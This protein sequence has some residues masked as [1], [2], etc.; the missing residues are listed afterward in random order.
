[1]FLLHCHGWTLVW[2]A[3]I[4]SWS[5]CGILMRSTSGISINLRLWSLWK[6][7]SREGLTERSW[8]VAIEMHSSRRR[9][10][11]HWDKKM[12][13]LCTT[14]TAWCRSRCRHWCWNFTPVE[15]ATH[16]CFCHSAFLLS[17][18]RIETAIWR[19]TVRIQELRSETCIE[20]LQ[21]PLQTLPHS[22]RSMRYDCNGFY[23]SYKS[24]FAFLRFWNMKVANQLLS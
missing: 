1:M 3:D 5:V 14:I 7:K 15:Q 16:Q 18:A 10:V 9:D 23:D 6:D 17:E 4:L 22:L 12:W 24:S 19:F 20:S 8:K 2:L 21:Q 13:P 11:E